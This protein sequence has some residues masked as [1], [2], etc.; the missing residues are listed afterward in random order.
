MVGYF[1]DIDTLHRIDRK[2]LYHLHPL[3]IQE[4]NKNVI[5]VLK[6]SWEFTGSDLC[7]RLLEQPHITFKLRSSLISLIHCLLFF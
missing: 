5:H 3:K 6:Y 1:L 7:P 2:V 4:I